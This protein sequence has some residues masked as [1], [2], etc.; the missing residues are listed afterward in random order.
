MY[1]AK[2]IANNILFKSYKLS[3]IKHFL[4]IITSDLIILE[5]IN[6]G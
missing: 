2:I 6:P 5:F 3:E 1:F 4:Q